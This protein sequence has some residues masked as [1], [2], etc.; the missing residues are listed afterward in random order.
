M[1]RH[2]CALRGPMPEPGRSDGK[3]LSRTGLRSVRDNNFHRKFDRAHHSAIVSIE[4]RV[5]N[6]QTRAIACAGPRRLSGANA[7]RA[8]LR[9]LQREGGASAD[10]GAASSDGEPDQC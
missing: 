7:P 1:A 10:F 4:A 2:A 5:P 6:T 9:G 8:Q 3:L